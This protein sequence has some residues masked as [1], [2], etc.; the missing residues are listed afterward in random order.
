MSEKKLVVDG[1]ELTYKGLFDLDGLLKK[2]DETTHTRGYAKVEKRRQELVKKE[3][4][5]FSMELR[6]TKIKSE[7]ESIMIKIRLNITDL[8]EVEVLIDKKKNKLQEGNI[9]MVFDAWKT[10]DWKWRWEKKPGIYFLRTLVDKF[11]KRF[12][13]GRHEGELIEDTQYVYTNVKGYLQL[14]RYLVD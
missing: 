14:H 9:A 6:P 1:L 2:I 3:G 10:T 13:Q 12:H 11:I 4:K 7:Y 8:K 5:E